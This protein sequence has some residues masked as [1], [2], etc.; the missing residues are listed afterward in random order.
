MST[1]V[2]GKPISR[3]EGPEKVRGQARYA[4]EIPIAG[5]RF[6]LLLGSTIAHGR[7][8]AFDSARAEAVPGVVGVL[9]HHNFPRLGMDIKSFPLGTAGT[10]L[11]PMQSD[12]IL[13][14][15]QYIACIVA[16]TIEAAH[17]AL[18]LIKIEYEAAPPITFEAALASSGIQPEELPKFLGD[19]LNTVR[20]DVTAARAASEFIVSNEYSTPAIYQSPIEI[21]A[22]IAVPDSNG[23]LTIYDATQ[24]ILGVRNALSRVLLMPLEKI[25]VITH[26][27]GGAFGAKCFTWP[28]TMI[29]AAAAREFEVPVK[30]FLNREQM[31]HGMGYR[32]PMAQRFSIGANRDG[33]LQFL[34]HD[35][36]SAT[37]ITDVD[38]PPAVEM[39]KVLYHCPNLRTRQRVYRCHVAT[40]CRMR[41][42]GEAIG[43]FA[44]E[45]AMDEL[46]YKLGIDPVEL[47]LRNYAEVHPETEKPW[48][49]KG[50]RQCYADGVQRFGWNNRNPRPMSYVDGD[51]FY[52]TGMSSAIYPTMM[53]PVESRVKLFADGA[54]LGQAATQE[55]GQGSITV[56][57]QILA[58]TL[59]LPLSRARFEMGD[60]DYPAAPVSGGSRGAVS[61]GT[62]VLNAAQDLIRQL[63]RLAVAD[64]NSPLFG[65]AA[66]QIEAHEGGLQLAG[67]PQSHDSFVNLL[68]RARLDFVEGHG[69]Y[70]PLNTTEAD[71][72]ITRA[73]TTRTLGPNGTDKHVYTYG[74]NFVEVRVHGLTSRVEVTRALGVYGAGR[75]L[76][77]KMAHSQAI[78]GI[79]FGIGFALTE[80]TVIDPRNGRIVTN[81]FG[82]Y[83]VPQNGVVPKIEAYF[84][85]EY[86]PYISPLGAK[87]VGEIGTTGT[88]A[89]VANAVFHATGK[90][91]YQL[92]IT[93]E[94]LL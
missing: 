18:G 91:V 23:S 36:V 58:D 17:N 41:A 80:E 40:P 75:I 15:G 50:L 10:R 9:S 90:R 20:G 94:R 24:H 30:L 31:F 69:I 51:W 29:A 45:T 22:T 42:P 85:D 1:S 67:Q 32:A 77:P 60:T 6:A 16:D 66:T 71:L 68:A 82:D 39:S 61:V 43:L 11:L 28:H 59:A 34:D 25:R 65:A 4:A 81:S 49:T 55:I 12:E 87:G 2:L 86:D 3:I 63:A 35:A 38:I 14:E 92:P 64:R 54:A 46:A 37:S 84:I 88:A 52:G 93:A 53:S 5:L 27:V 89:A 48:S 78:G 57:T 79:A 73:G 62:A 83:Y 44:I 26:Y 21:G 7:I 47:R 33:V 13:Y 76:N 70:F 56:L 8:Q 19:S 74:A 72:A